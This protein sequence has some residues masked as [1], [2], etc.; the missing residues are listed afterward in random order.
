MST[1]TKESATIA[2]SKL[3]L[4]ATENAFAYDHTRAL[5]LIEQALALSPDSGRYAT[6]KAEIL[7]ELGRTRDA[8]KYLQG[9]HCV[10]D[11]HMVAEELKT[12]RDEIKDLENTGEGMKELNLLLAWGAENGVDLS[13]V[14][15]VNYSKDFRGIHAAR[16]IRKG[17]RIL[18]VPE[19]LLVHLDSILATC[20]LAKKVLDSGARLMYPTATAVACLVH[21]ARKDPTSWW[22]HYAASFPDDVSTY[23]YFFPSEERKF[24]QGTTVESRIGYDVDCCR[25]E[26]DIICEHLPEFAHEISFDAYLRLTTIACSRYFSVPEVRGELLAVPIVDMFNYYVEK[27]GQTKWGYDEDTKSFSVVA[28]QD[29]ARNEVIGLNYGDHSNAS[30]LLSYGFFPENNPHRYIFIQ[31]QLDPKDPLLSKK[32]SLVCYDPD[33]FALHE[34][35]FAFTYTDDS[36]MALASLRYVVYDGDP[37]SLTQY[38]DQKATSAKRYCEIRVPPQSVQNEAKMLELFSEILREK[39]S[40][41]PESPEKDEATLRSE[42]ILSLNARNALMVRVEEQQ[43]IMKGI[44]FVEHALK[45]LRGTKKEAEKETNEMPADAPCKYYFEHELLPLLK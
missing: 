11:T 1:T 6:E 21:E 35:K 14:K 17:D 13:R 42:K 29:I 22:K 34:W 12:L 10:Q 18:S 20:K 43:D 25:D 19:K 40:L 3:A 8:L 26:Y 36:A 5:A 16:R 15:L 31:P 2:A 23:P 7:C 44:E 24:L 45:L 30:F 9:V 38:V 28:L 4:Q 37:S 33:D 41:F 39:L 32:Q 27:V